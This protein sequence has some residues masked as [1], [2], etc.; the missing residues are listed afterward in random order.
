MDD[1]KLTILCAGSGT[2]GGTL[3]ASLLYGGTGI[4][5]AG[6]IEV[7]CYAALSAV[8]AYLTKIGIDRLLGF[9]KK[10]RIL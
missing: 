7:M 3:K 1:S 5:S 6:L 10:R 8:T 9:I 2:L 4:S